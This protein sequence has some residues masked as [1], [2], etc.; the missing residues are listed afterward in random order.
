MAAGQSDYEARYK[1]V[2]KSYSFPSDCEE[3]IQNWEKLELKCMMKKDIRTALPGISPSPSGQTKKTGLWSG[4]CGRIVAEKPE[5]PVFATIR[6][7]ILNW[8][9]P[10]DN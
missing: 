8:E 4:N 3:A 10:K 6:R 2:I 7:L 9:A 5:M 1:K